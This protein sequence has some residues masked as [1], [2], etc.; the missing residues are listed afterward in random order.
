M[1]HNCPFCDCNDDPSNYSISKWEHPQYNT[2][3]NICEINKILIDMA[4]CCDNCVIYC[5]KC[6]RYSCKNHQVDKN[7]TTCQLCLNTK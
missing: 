2:F 1:R 3:C 4:E 5:V 6:Q 7:E